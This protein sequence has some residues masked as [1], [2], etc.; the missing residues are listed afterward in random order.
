[1]FVLV[2]ILLLISN[3]QS[4]IF[5]FMMGSLAILSLI[6]VISL[7]IKT[8][9]ARVYSSVLIG[10]LGLFY[11]VGTVLSL[12]RQNDSGT[13]VMFIAFCLFFWWC[14]SLAF[15]KAASDYFSYK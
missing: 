6:A 5:V 7:Y 12:V 15:G 8:K 10:L 13:H 1:M 11:L 4:K 9:W 2:G 3:L 14:C